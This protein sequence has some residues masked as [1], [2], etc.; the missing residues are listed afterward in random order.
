MP[1]EYRCMCGRNMRRAS[2]RES[3]GTR[4]ATWRAFEGTRGAPR[5]ANLKERVSS[6]VREGC[7]NHFR[8]GLSLTIGVGVK[9][10]IVELVNYL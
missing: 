2:W 5:G 7:K 3:E 9:E 1:P 6:R 4:G 8:A 10:R